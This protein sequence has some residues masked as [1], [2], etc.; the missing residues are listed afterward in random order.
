[1]NPI[2]IFEDNQSAIAM[3][4]NRQFHG[5]SKHF[6]IKYHYVRDQVTK[7]TF[8]LKYCPTTEMVADLL[9]KRLPQDQFMKLRKMIRLDKCSD[10]ECGGVLEQ[11]T[12]A[13]HMH[14]LNIVCML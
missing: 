6:D 1:M 5:H 7:G 3:S 4:C 2:I 10:S 13:K 14:V 8:K 9:T 11:Y 12:F